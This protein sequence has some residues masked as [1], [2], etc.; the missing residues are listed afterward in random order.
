MRGCHRT[1][2]ATRASACGCTATTP[3]ER[4][5]WTSW[6]T[7][8][9]AR[10]R[11]DAERWS[12]DIPDNFS[13]WQFFQFTWDDFNRKDIG[14]GAPNDGFTLTEVHGYAVGG[15]G[16]VDMGSQSYYV[17]QVS[18]FGNTGGVV[19][20]LQVEFASSNYEVTE[21]D[22]AMITVTLNMTSTAPVSIAYTTA[23]GYATPDRNYVPTSGVLV[24]DPGQLEQTFPVATLHDGKPSGDQKLMLNLLDPTGADAGFQVQAML[25]IL[26]VDPRRSDH[27]RR[28]PG[29]PS[30]R[31]VRRR[32]PVDHRA[33][34]GH[35]H[36]AARAVDLRGRADG[37]LRPGRARPASPVS[38]RRARTGAATAPSAS[39]TTAAT[40][41]RRSPSTC[42]TTRPRRLPRPRPASG[43][44]SG[45]M[46]STTRAAL[47]PI[48]T[49]GRTRS[50]T[51][52]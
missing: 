24:I 41:A 22:T 52:R 37:H 44:W 45:A 36:G 23:E 21:G 20:P 10:P 26:D 3:A 50:A 49:S 43:N 51:A 48:P 18:I 29:L 7:A 40:A 35:G 33:D 38:S 17:D 31:S 27:D 28:L 19:E 2:A 6:T 47:A 46:S 9:P 32:G 5:S 16:N 1:G 30:L 15:Y 14:N 4:S 11:D 39:G 13:G 34:D 42:W 25:T 12:L 8:T